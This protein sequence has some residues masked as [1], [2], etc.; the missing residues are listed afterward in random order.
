MYKRCGFRTRKTSGNVSLFMWLSFCWGP[1]ILSPRFLGTE[2]RN[3]GRCQEPP[4]RFCGVADG[5]C[6][7]QLGTFFFFTCQLISVEGI[8]RSPAKVELDLEWDEDMVVSLLEF[9]CAGSLLSSYA[10]RSLDKPVRRRTQLLESCSWFRLERLGICVDTR[11]AGCR[12]CVKV[13]HVLLQG[14]T[15]RPDDTCTTVVPARNTEVIEEI[16]Q[17][18]TGVVNKEIRDI[19]S[20]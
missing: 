14:A 17:E 12:Q 6:F 20:K 8:R 10:E 3:H 9:L 2:I 5:D 18:R 16:M 11:Q 7:Q 4:C 15:S 19:F 1:T 13:E